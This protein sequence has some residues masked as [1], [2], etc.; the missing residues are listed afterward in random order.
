MMKALAFSS[1]GLVML[2]MMP[3]PVWS[4]VC[5]MSFEP[6][7]VARLWRPTSFPNVLIHELEVHCNNL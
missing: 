3:C 4:V 5:N 1:M 2:Q 6:V 7:F